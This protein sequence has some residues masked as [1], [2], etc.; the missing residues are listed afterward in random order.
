MIVTTQNN[1]YKNGHRKR[2]LNE[3]VSCNTAFIMCQA[4]GVLIGIAAS[5]CYCIVSCIL[6]IELTNP[7]TASPKMTALSDYQL[8]NLNP[9]LT[10]NFGLRP[11][12]SQV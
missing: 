9:C 2:G 6:C 1:Y 12:S 4:G 10:L 7:Y 11:F 8:L 3:I 5:Y